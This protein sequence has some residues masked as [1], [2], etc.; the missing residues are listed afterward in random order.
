MANRPLPP[1]NLYLSIFRATVILLALA[2]AFSLVYQKERQPEKINL[3]D[4]AKKIEA[5][6]V[7]KI[8]V[9]GNNLEITLK[10]GQVVN[11][12]KESEASLTETLSRYNI[13]PQA[14][15]AVA[16]EVKEESGVAFWL[17]LLLPVVLPLLL[18]GFFFWMLIR[19]AR[20]GVNQ[21]FTFGRANIRLVSGQKEKVTFADV[22]GLKEAKKEL[23]E[24]VD[25]LKEPKKYLEMGAKVP[26]GVL[27]MGPPGTGKTLLARAVSGESGVPF[28]HISASE[29]VEMF[30]GVGASRIRDSF[31]TAKRAAPSI[32]FIDE[33]DAVG[34]E[35]GAGLGGGHDEREQT[36]NQILVE[37]D[38]FDQDTRVIVIAA[39]VAGDTPV[40]VKKGNECF[41]MPIADVIDPYYEGDEEAVEKA[42]NGDF[43]VLGYES[44]P[45]RRHH[46]KKAVFQPVKSVFRHRVKEIYEIEYL[47]GTIRATGNHSVFIRSKRGIE[48][49]AVADLKPGDILADLPY[50]VNR[51]NKKLRQIR[52]Y[53]PTSAFNLELPVWQPLFQPYT[54]ATGS[55]QYVLAHREEYS[56]AALGKMFGLSQTAIGKWLRGVN[57]PRVLSRNY[58]QHQNVL[59]EKVRVTPRLMRLLGYYAA[60]GYARKEVDFCLNINEKEKIED[61]KGLMKE[62]FGVEPS[63]ERQITPGAIN[64][65][66]YSKPLAVFFG[67]HCGKGASNKHLPPFLFIAP[68]EYFIEFLRGYFAGDGYKDKRGRI[69][70]TSTSKRLILELNW[71]SR[72]HGFKSYINSFQTKAGRRIGAGKPLKSST[73]W[74]IGF[75]KT[76]NPL[77]LVPGKAST[78][79]AIVRRVKKIPFDGFVY[80]FCGCKNEAFFG[81]TSPVLLH[82]T[83][84]PD[85]LD[86]A[87]LRP[88]RFDRRVVLDL[89][90]IKE[91]EEILK[92]H[93]RNKK[94]GPDVD[95]AKLAARTPGFSGA[96][97]ANLINEAAILA[98]QEGQKEIS[99]RHIYDSIEKVILGPARKS[100]LVSEKEREITAY[101]EAGHA[102]VS[103]SL[104]DAD[105][106][107]KVSIVAR[108]RAGG[109]TLNLPL[110]DRRLKTK[111]QFL[112]DLAVMLGG[113]ASEEI[114]F[115]D[116]STGAAN[117][118]RE[119]SSLARQLVTR[120][121][122]SEKLGPL[123]F[124]KTEELIFLGREITTEKNYSEQVAAKIDEEVQ[125]FIN[126]AHQKAKQIITKHKNA[127]RA[128]AQALMEKEVLEQEEFYNLIKPFK[129]KPVKA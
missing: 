81:G 96:D 24:I 107:T 1:N 93:A 98:V 78:K 30:V 110:E 114:I 65:V 2:L 108:G 48:T 39:S 69:Q 104:K 54:A 32:L 70:I 27:L 82:N 47:G 112:A 124:G 34:R 97:L 16:L 26:R 120:Y 92:I 3:A 9:A 91:R 59:P 53:E 125:A 128:I 37:M 36:L 56:Q 62:I 14:L 6:E 35:R 63:R 89:P 122:M 87:L 90:D 66:Y 127:L 43:E 13:P 50:K 77:E 79:R 7:A 72:M 8:T 95:F 85:I 102:L 123:T 99:Q 49:V 23:E 46:F 116:V 126:R 45:R 18:I 109:Y 4:L 52:A 68:K 12:R 84:R 80:D 42:I 115:K 19:Q 76:Q 44:K 20:T 28:F 129:L 33:I 64:L 51:T 29:F 55:Y 111:S 75:G 40:L 60:E 121:G 119:A 71:L 100:R 25:F 106:V 86:Q 118:L 11:S 10:N 57:G 88:G 15:S 103:A 117:D 83:N 41:L 67:K 73:A 31:Q 5:G 101:H 22:A 58:F 61:I 38:G 74:R 94:L 17:G 105:P 113:F 21:A